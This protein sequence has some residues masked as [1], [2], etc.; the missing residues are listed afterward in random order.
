M[1]TRSTLPSKRLVDEETQRGSEGFFVP[2]KYREGG[3]AAAMLTER[4]NAGAEKTRLHRSVCEPARRKITHSAT[5][6][7]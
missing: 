2:A 5:C 4:D 7:G 1:I 6:A 3:A